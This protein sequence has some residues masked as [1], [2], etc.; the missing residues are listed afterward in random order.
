MRRSEPVWQP[1]LGGDQGA[2]LLL[3]ALSTPGKLPA[4]GEAS[5]REGVGGPLP[6]RPFDNLPQRVPIAPPSEL[7]PDPAAARVQ[8]RIGGV[9]LLDHYFAQRQR[10]DGARDSTHAPTLL[11]IIL[12]CPAPTLGQVRHVWAL[13]HSPLPACNVSGMRRVGLIISTARWPA[14]RKFGFPHGQSR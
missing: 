14:N 4:A 3:N 6:W 1:T 8:L 13:P 12:P 10:L 9:N 5:A 7:E 11:L 2:T